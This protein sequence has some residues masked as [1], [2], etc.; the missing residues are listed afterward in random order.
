MELSV[1]IILHQ[2][3]GFL[4]HLLAVAV[5]QLDAVIIVGIVAGRDHD[6]AVKVIHTSDV[7]YRR[8]GSNVQQIGVCARSSQT[9][10]QAILEH[11][12]TPTSILADDN[13]GRVGITIALTESIVIPAQESTYF[14]GMVCC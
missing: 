4:R 1:D 7:S 5:D 6:A 10:D 2:Q 11:V 3:Q 12:R 8:R 13:T 9:S 14:V